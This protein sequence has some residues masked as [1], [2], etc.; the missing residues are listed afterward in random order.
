M[1][2]NPKHDGTHKTPEKCRSPGY[3]L[4]CP[5]S[6]KTLKNATP[7][8][9]LCSLSGHAASPTIFG[10]RSLNHSPHH[11]HMVT[12]ICWPK[13]NLTQGLPR[14]KVNGLSCIGW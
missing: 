2:S 10:C 3:T 4:I 1:I 14:F 9:F 13:N 7:I 6:R 8:V 11:M 5:L 12:H